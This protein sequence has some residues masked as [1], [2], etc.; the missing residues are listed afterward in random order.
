[1][2]CFMKSLVLDLLQPLCAQLPSIA[3]GICEMEPETVAGL[4]SQV[5]Q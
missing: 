5:P 1:M 4:Q 3:K 2:F